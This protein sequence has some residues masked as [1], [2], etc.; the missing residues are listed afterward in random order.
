MP[1]ITM[2][3]NTKC[4]VKS[5]CYRYMAK[6]DRLQSFANY[7]EKNHTECF[8]RITNGIDKE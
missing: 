2:C 7:D 6:P 1:D 8:V 3:K 5:H 4:F